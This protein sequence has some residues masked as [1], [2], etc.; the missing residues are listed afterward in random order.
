[1][2]GVAGKRFLVTGADGFIGSHLV[3]RLYAEG[4]KVRALVYYNAFG[5]WGWLDELPPDVLN[6]VEVVTGDVRDSEH[7]RKAAKDCD[8]IFHLAALIGIPYSYHAPRSYYDTNAL[9]TLNILQAA[10]DAGTERVI[11]T[12]T[13]EVYGT[14]REVPIS[15]THPRQ[16]QSPYSASKIAADALANSFYL[17][18]GLPVVIA[19]PFNTF[20]PR[21]SARAIIP[22][23]I[24]QLLGGSDEVRLGALHP[25]RDLVFVKDTVEGLIRLGTSPTAIG[26]EVNIA[27]GR[28]IAMGDLAHLLIQMIRPGARVIMETQRLRPENSEVDR[29]LGDVRLLE[30]LSG[31]RPGTELEDGLSQTI[32]WYRQHPDPKRY[33]TDAFTL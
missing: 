23:I 12:S 4:A 20:G 17:S 10:R 18:F 26:R 5:H 22:T 1:M 25:T 29:L 27:T 19:R 31:W 13:S 33:K 8:T 24:T 14:A 15:E 28:E 16:A 11:V 7:I 21:Q 32:E 2:E 30:Q 3:E 6:D 9:G